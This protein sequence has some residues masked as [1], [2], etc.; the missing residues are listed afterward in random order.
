MVDTWAESAEFHAEQDIKK[1]WFSDLVIL[2]IYK[3]LMKN[4][5][6][7]DAPTRIKVLYTKKARTQ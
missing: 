6:Q 1:G 3:Q 5:Y 4:E 7:Q 2:E